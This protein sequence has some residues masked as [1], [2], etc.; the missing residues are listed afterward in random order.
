MNY[1]SWK[2][3]D[4]KAELKRR[5]I[6]QTGLRLK[7]QIVEKLLESD[8]SERPAP[9]ED[10]V[11]EKTVVTE[12]D[13]APEPEPEV[14]QGQE[15]EQQLGEGSGT[16]SRVESNE[17]RQTSEP[18]GPAEQSPNATEA[19]VPTAEPALDEKTENSTAQADN[20]FKPASDAVVESTSEQSQPSNE[21]AEKPPSPRASDQAV[22][23][24]GK[25]LER[26]AVPPVSS[27]PEAAPSEP[28]PTQLPELLREESVDD[29]KK[30]KRRS[31]S[32]PPSPRTMALKRA[33]ADNGEPRDIVSHESETPQVEQKSPA[34]PAVPPR[35]TDVEMSTEDQA[36]ELQTEDAG[37]LIERAP[38][39]QRKDEK[40]LDKD[41]KTGVPEQ[42]AS[43]PTQ[44]VQEAHTEKAGESQTTRRA[45]ADPRF[46][47]LFPPAN[48][49]HLRPEPLSHLED[50]DREVEPALHPATTSLYIRD[51]MRPLQP[52]A[53]KMHLAS[54]A[55]PPGSSPDPNVIL[56]FF[57]DPIKTHCFITFSTVSAAS[58]VRTALHGTIWPEERS[59]KPLWVDFI[60]EEKVNEW[61]DTEQAAGNGGRGA[62][63][64]EVSYETT[65]D[66]VTA[67][68]REAVPPHMQG[69]D[70]GI[71]PPSGPRADRYMHRGDPPPHSDHGFKALDD[72][73]LSTT[74]KPKLYYLPVPREVAD[75]RLDR[76]DDLARAG[77]VDRR[78]GDE[79]R[80]YTFED[81]DFFVDNGPEYGRR[82]RRGGRGRGFDDF[83]RSWRE[84]SWRGRW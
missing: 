27:A 16:Q 65:E 78:G 64:W 84:G 50:E 70:L 73:F 18:E 58:R 21:T 2:V 79:M 66:G 61:I 77:P 56:T 26:N 12:S 55:A 28:E 8:E 72:R 82:G 71:H 81:T 52:A 47:G 13:P 69:R 83:G 48:G 62:P 43:H 68:L 22:E 32:P 63:R 80:R 29:S 1:Y 44:E 40:Y 7:Q 76:F 60:P 5:G 15:H 10:A 30:R 31:Q 17:G 34:R 37:G 25:S 11:Q 23:E 53:V 59:R 38:S 35:V 36:K 41:P 45:T 20:A 74:A 19:Q 57:L 49:E 14:E 4:L 46:K 6:P 3:T 42:E 33:K 9:A 54:L 39:P 75:R 67:V 51:F 24:P